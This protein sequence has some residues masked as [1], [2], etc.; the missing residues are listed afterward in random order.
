VATTFFV[1]LPAEHWR[2]DYFHSAIG[3]KRLSGN[4]G[5][6]WYKG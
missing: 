2:G 6:T 1:S 3:Q 4:I 5:K